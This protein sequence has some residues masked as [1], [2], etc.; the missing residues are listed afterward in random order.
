VKA[1]E[2]A[3]R[4]IMRNSGAVDYCLF[5]GHSSE[6]R[7]SGALFS[8]GKGKKVVAGARIPARALRHYLHITPLQ[9]VT[10]WRRT[11]VGHLHANAVGY[12]G[13]YANGLAALFIACGQDVANIVNSA[14]GITNFE[15]AENDSVYVSVTLPS[16]TVATVGGGTGLGTGVECLRLLGVAG[17][18]GAPKLAEIAAATL[19]AGEISMAAAIASG[20]FV[21]A[22]EDYGRN[23]PES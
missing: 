16:L 12:N 5:S 6:K 15:L 20:E 18:A 21:R 7:A 14:V 10:L 11:V 19:L 9:L 17:R 22:H 2:Q 13:H 1:T 4:W 23:R 8:G 3:C